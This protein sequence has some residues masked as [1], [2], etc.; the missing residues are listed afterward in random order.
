MGCAGARG[1]PSVLVG[2]GTRERRGFVGGGGLGVA[3]GHAD[4]SLLRANARDTWPEHARALEESLAP[5]YG[6]PVDLGRLRFH[7]ELDPLTWG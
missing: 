5:R 1:L 2:A 7:L 4:R 6:S 3:D